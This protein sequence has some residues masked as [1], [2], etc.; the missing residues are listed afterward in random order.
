MLVTTRFAAIRF[1]LSLALLAACREAPAAASG[2]VTYTVVTPAAP[3]AGCTL[4]APSERSG[5]LA[6]LVTFH[7]DR[8]HATSSPA[9]KWRD[10]AIARG[11][12]VLGLECPVSLGCVD[13]RWY[14]ANPSPSWVAE[15]I[16]AVARE[17]P[18][19]RSRVYL[20]GWSGG[21]SYLGMNA[22]AWDGKA[23]AVVFHGGGQP[24]LASDLCPVGQLP[25]YFL[26]GDENP[27]HGATKRLRTY[28]DR[29]KQELAWELLPGAGHHDEAQ[30]LDRAKADQIISWLES[31]AHA[32]GHD[33]VAG[34]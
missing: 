24:P 8:E 29:C 28:L 32:P 22:P 6:L 3:C 7:G 15:Q 20:A 19:D 30:A 4:A 13:G 34:S 33:L 5:D 17:L 31:H 14:I 1:G 18:I 9:T 10:A 16:D 21:A 26:V 25:A 11:F 2:R 27:A 23:A 12:V